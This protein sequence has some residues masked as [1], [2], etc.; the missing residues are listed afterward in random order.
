MESVKTL[1]IKRGMSFKTFVLGTLLSVLMITIVSFSAYTFVG[2]SKFAGH[3]QVINATDF[4]ARV[5]TATAHTLY[6][7]SSC[8][9]IIGA[10]FFVIP[11]IAL[12][13]YYK[14]TVA[15]SEF[16]NLPKVLQALVVVALV[17]M[18][19]FGLFLIGY[20]LAVINNVFMIGVC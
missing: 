16:K 8:G 15:M 9:I 3:D 19:M 17:V 11:R 4:L 5:L 2:L 20:D 18:I 7:I 10:C 14:E 12:Y 13:V 1:D 6:S